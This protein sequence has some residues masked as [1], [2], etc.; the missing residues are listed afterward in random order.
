M[1][2][3]L[4]L[5]IMNKCLFV[6]VDDNI[7]IFIVVVPGVNGCKGYTF[8]FLLD[9]YSVYILAVPKGKCG[10]AKPCPAD[11]LAFKIYSGATNIVG[12]QICFDGKV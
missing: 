11:G 7:D 6:G 2:K 8:K 12:P 9:F 10:L 4:L 1:P 5:L 3:L